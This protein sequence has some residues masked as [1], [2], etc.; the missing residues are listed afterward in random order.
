MG[1]SSAATSLQ[2]L[3]RLEEERQNDVRR[4]VLRR[5][6]ADD[7]ARRDA[8]RRAEEAE[9]AQKRSEDERVRAEASRD[10]E[11]AARHRAME[12]AAVEHERL[13]ATARAHAAE[14]MLQREH[15]VAMEKLRLD[16][17]LAGARRWV[18][19]V[20][21]VAVAAVTGGVMLYALQLKPTSDRALAAAVGDVAARDLTVGQLRARAESAERD[22]EQAA[23][24]LEAARRD[25]ARLARENAEMR[26]AIDAAK[27]PK[28]HVGGAATHEKAS[29]PACN[30]KD[31]MCFDLPK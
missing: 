26:R 31:P 17:A 8:E 23:R 5:R 18:V 22:G 11:E 6:E 19:V 24:E 4:A 10:R 3:M 12:A 21:T 9:H 13:A 30:P 2:E 16:A 20:A 29:S 28:G 14:Q 27:A 1:E 15:D 7:E 25:S